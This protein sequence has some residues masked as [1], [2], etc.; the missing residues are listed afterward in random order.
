MR[1]TYRSKTS[2]VLI[3]TMNVSHTIYFGEGVC[4]LFELIHLYAYPLIVYLMLQIGTQF[5]TG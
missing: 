2:A 3:D 4:N 1:E 5:T